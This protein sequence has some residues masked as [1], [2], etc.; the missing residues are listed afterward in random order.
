MVDQV[1]YSGRLATKLVTCIS[2]PPNTHFSLKTN[3]YPLGGGWSLRKTKVNKTSKSRNMFTVRFK[4]RPL[5]S[6]LL[7]QEIKVSVQR[8]QQTE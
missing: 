1:D 5:F 8:L 3:S 7:I 4:S 6:Y 2:F